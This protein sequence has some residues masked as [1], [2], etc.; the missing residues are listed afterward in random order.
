[1]AADGGLAAAG[2]ADQGDGQGG[3]SDG[4]GTPRTTVTDT[5]VAVPLG[6]VKVM[7]IRP[8][9]TDTSVNP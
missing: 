2:H 7:N 9:F 5:V 8:E 6:E 3:Q 4:R 1:M